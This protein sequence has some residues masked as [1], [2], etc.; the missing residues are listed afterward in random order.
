[1]ESRPDSASALSADAELPDSAHKCSVC[2]SCCHSL[3]VAQSLFWLSFSPVPQ[4]V[5]SEPFLLI[6]STPTTVLDKPPRA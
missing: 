6:L 1:M 4:A 2:A 3:A 5:L